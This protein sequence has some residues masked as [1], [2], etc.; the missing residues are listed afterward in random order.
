[1]QLELYYHRSQI[2]AHSEACAAQAGTLDLFGDEDIHDWK[3]RAEYV[4]VAI[5]LLFLAEN[6]GL[7]YGEGMWCVAAVLRCFLPVRW[8]AVAVP[9]ITCGVWC[10]LLVL[11]LPPPLRA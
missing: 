7:M 1:M 2:E 3:V 8:V 9:C 10:A 5:L 11:I 6:F 4:S